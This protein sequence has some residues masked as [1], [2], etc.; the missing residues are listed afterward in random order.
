MDNSKKKKGKKIPFS[1][2]KN[3]FTNSLFEVESFLQKS[4]KIC[5]AWE[6]GKFIKDI[7][8]NKNN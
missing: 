2:I 6:T 5:K 3:N 1:Q 8:S 7:S 4:N